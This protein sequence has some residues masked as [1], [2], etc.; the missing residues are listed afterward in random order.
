MTVI[1]TNWTHIGPKT[2]VTFTVALSL[3]LL[4]GAFFIGAHMVRS[5]ARRGFRYLSG[6]NLV[7]RRPVAADDIRVA[8]DVSMTE[9]RDLALTRWGNGGGD[10]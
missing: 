5:H 3:G 1:A 4:L 9:E 6:V 8:F 10:D 7:E 2:I